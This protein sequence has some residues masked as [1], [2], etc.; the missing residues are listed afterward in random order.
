MAA[1]VV[2]GSGAIIRQYF[3]D[4]WY[5]CGSKDCFLGQALKPSG[6]LV[7]AVLMNGAQAL[8]GVKA[9]NVFDHEE[10]SPYDSIQNMGRINLLKSLPLVGE[11]DIDLVVTNNKELS[12]GQKEDIT[13]EVTCDTETLS[14]TLSW[15]DPASLPGCVNC[16]VNNLDLSIQRFDLEGNQ[17]GAVKHPNGK[18]TADMVNNNERIQLSVSSGERYTISVTA[19]SIAVTGTTQKYS[20]VGTG[21]FKVLVQPNST[22]PHNSNILP[23]HSTDKEIDGT[24]LATSSHT[25]MK[26]SNRVKFIPTG[27]R[28][29]LRCKK[30]AK[31]KKQKANH[32]S[33]NEGINT[34]A[35]A[36]CPETCG[37][38]NIFSACNDTKVIFGFGS[39]GENL[40]CDWLKA[41][42]SRK[43][44]YC[45]S[46]NQ[47]KYAA[48]AVCPLT[49]GWC[50]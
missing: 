28:R 48:D 2:S 5:P 50:G 38:H 11:N 40:T 19:R 49:C 46:G 27:L 25:S 44:K 30:L 21:C 9:S 33:K 37:K 43:K 39:G 20:L 35:D 15:Y 14:F 17:N 8:T 36:V 45:S 1:P 34:L 42:K 24:L 31:R 47:R 6:A 7:K 18:S 22:R 26:N 29:P 10:I 12:Q 13:I 23:Q 16:L 4:G 3:E 41:S 32:C